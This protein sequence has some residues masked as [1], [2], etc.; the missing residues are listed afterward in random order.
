[1]R[2]TT[3]LLAATAALALGVAALGGCS[4]GDSDGPDDPTPAAGGHVKTP[5]PQDD[6]AGA[7][8]T[9]TDEGAGD[10]GDGEGGLAACL[11]GTWVLD[12]QSVIDATIAS[13]GMPEGTSA[14][15]ITVTGDA[16]MTF[17]PDGA[18]RTE[19]QQQLAD[20][21]ID[22]GGQVLRTV[23]SMDGVLV[24]TYTVSADT[25]TLSDLDASGVTADVTATID[26]A[27]YD[28]GDAA[29]M[30]IAG[31][32]VGGSMTATCSGDELQVVPTTPGATATFSAT[33]HRS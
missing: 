16:V 31:L 21:T 1:M 13:M 26:D 22:I 10:T 19:Y 2:R 6:G 11:A 28:V 32:E 4:G 30:S 5:A 14:P 17:G 23:S 8:D 25:V 15:E 24:G 9:D 3:A 18:L 27:P 29:A 33:Y 12:R 7:E 20:M